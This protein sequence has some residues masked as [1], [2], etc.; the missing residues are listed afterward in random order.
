MAEPAA[1][2]AA[3]ARFKAASA[4]GPDWARTVTACL[5]ALGEPPPGANLGL[6]YA[7]GALAGNL[8]AILTF[9]RENTGVED[10]V[11]TVGS[12]VAASGVEYHDRPALA[13]LVGALPDDGYRVFQPLR[14]SL[15]PFK[16]DHGAWVAHHR[17]IFG[18]VH[19]DPRNHHVGEILEALAAEASVYL[20]G[21]LAAG[22]GALPQV[23]GAVADGG[24]SGVLF[25][26][27]LPVV[28]GLTQGCTPI[29]EPR[30]ITKAEHN[31][32]MEID[33]RPAVEV[34]KQDIGE[35]LA[36]D[37]RRVGGYIYVAF[38]IAGND[39][40]DYLVRNLTG[41]DLERGWLAVG[42]MVAEGQRLMFCRRDHEA[43][44]QDLKRMLADVKRRAPG[45]PKAALYVACV[46][47]GPNLFGSESEE[48][49]LIAEELGDLPL[50]GFFANGEISN[51]RL[52]G[53]TGVLA[54]FL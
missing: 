3:Q 34:F 49:K 4:A 1:G 31:V 6:L 2:A 48:L 40:G 22:D 28:A 47:R 39:T 33:G 9:L 52:Y 12:G 10:W 21:G 18:I 44:R 25:S 37:L 42:E 41:I 14:D 38:P 7:T 29:G 46:A 53:Y 13:L 54:L 8:E 26:P 20:V 35:L 50:V 27:E 36:R 11:G 30:A 19:G 17:P 32:I 51:N 16:R 23:A 45:P 24:L 43:A 5:E 15:E